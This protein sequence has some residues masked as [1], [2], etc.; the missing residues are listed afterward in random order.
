MFLNDKEID[1]LISAGAIENVYFGGH[2]HFDRNSPV[3]PCSLD[4]KVGK[5]YLP[6]ARPGQDG[7]AENP[8]ESHHIVPVGA[9]VVVETAEVFHLPH[10]IGAFGFPP[11]SVSNI[12]ILVTNLGHLDPGYHGTVRFTLVNMG[13]NPYPLR[14]GESIYTT[15]LFR[16]GPPVA[17]YEA[18]N[19]P[20]SRENPLVGVKSEMLAG[21]PPDFLDLDRRARSAARKA[22][23][24]NVKFVGTALVT[25][26][27]LIALVAN[28]V[29][30][31]D[32]VAELRD[33]VA[34]YKTL[35]MESIKAEGLI[36]ELQ[37]QI[38]DNAAT[39][40]AVRLKLDALGANVQPHRE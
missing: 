27:A 31:R 14:R 20:L 38:E 19:P 21:L 35:A 2:D 30:N 22:V 29:I 23:A 36:K 3:Q 1:A 5:I 4:L 13:R 26:G 32:R 12:G 10:T 33:Q 25:A 16:V 8:I 37:V 40:D 24:G 15:L 28:I 18:R 6:S 9:T 17:D 7:S 39:V 34:D 11:T